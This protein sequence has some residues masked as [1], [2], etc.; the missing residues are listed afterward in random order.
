ME[1]VLKNLRETRGQIKR[2]RKA[3]EEAL[4]EQ[5]RLVLAGLAAGMKSKQIAKE[6]GLSKQRI[7]QIKTAESPPED[8]SPGL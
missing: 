1:Q 4:D 8:Q 2:R 3:L 7:S 5:K 6:T